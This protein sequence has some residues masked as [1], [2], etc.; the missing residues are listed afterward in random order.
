MDFHA[1]LASQLLKQPPAVNAAARAGDPHDDPQIRL[2]L[3]SLGA[4]STVFSKFH[5]CGFLCSEFRTT[6]P[7]NAPCSTDGKTGIIA[8]SPGRTSVRQQRMG[9]ADGLTRIP[10][11]I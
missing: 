9:P 2:S 1:R 3:F 5:G 7:C 6:I 4:K 8:P 10:A 11:L